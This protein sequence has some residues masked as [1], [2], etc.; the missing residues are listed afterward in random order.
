M[1][2]SLSLAVMLAAIV[3]FILPF[4]LNGLSFAFQ[5]NVEERMK[6]KMPFM[7]GKAPVRPRCQGR[8]GLAFI[9]AKRRPLTQEADGAGARFGKEGQ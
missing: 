6:S 2:L 3:A 1:E 4:A 7:R 5:A 9:G 8:R